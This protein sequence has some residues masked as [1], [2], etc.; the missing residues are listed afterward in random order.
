MIPIFEYLAV[1]I[2]GLG[3]WLLGRMRPDLVA[4]LGQLV[5]RIMHNRNTRLA[6]IAIWWWLGWHFFTSI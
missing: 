6:I 1:I 3:V 2:I 5:A 4:P